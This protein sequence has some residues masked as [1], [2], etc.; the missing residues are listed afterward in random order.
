MLR[1]LTRSKVCSTLV[2]LFLGGVNSNAL[3]GSAMNPASTPPDAAQAASARRALDLLA[4]MTVEEKVGQLSQFFYIDASPTM[5]RRVETA[6]AGG[7]AGAVLFVSDPVKI[8]RLQKMAVEQ[9]RLK[10]PL[11]VGYDVIHGWNTILPVPIALAASWDPSVAEKAQAVAAAEASAA[12][13][14]WTFAPMIDV[15]LDPRWGRRVEGL[16]EDP[17]LGSAMTA[18]Q[19][20]GFQGPRLG[21]PAR[22]MAGPKHFAG[23]GAGMGGRDYDEAEISDSQLWNAYF[24]PFKAA[25]D[26]GAGNIMSAYMALN[27]VP[28]TGNHWL[29]TDVLRQTWGFKGFVVSDADAVSSLTRH[30]LSASASEAATLALKAGVNMEMISPMGAPVMPNIA[31]AIS[32][33]TV[34]VAELD[35]AV[36]PILET[37][38]R[39]GLFEHPYVDEAKA[40]QVAHSAAHDEVA[41]MAAERSAVL[42][43]NEGGLLPLN[44]ASLKSLAVIGPLA[45][46]GKDTLGPWA[47]QAKGPGVSVLEGLKARL[48][49]GVTI[50]HVDGVHLPARVFPSP[51]AAMNPTPPQPPIDEDA[52]IANAVH[53]ARQADVTVLVLGEGQDMAGEAASRASL[54]LP[55]RQQELLDA[56]VATGKPVVVLLMSSRPLN[57]HDT[58]AAA[59]MDI[60]YPGSQGGAAVARLLLG[61]VSPAG[62]LPFSWIRSAAQAPMTYAQLI[63]HEPQGAFKR[64]WDG[65][66][67]PTY[68]FGYG[69]SYTSFDYSHL[70]IEGEHHAIGDTVHVS[71]DVTNTGQRQCDEVAQL[72]LHQRSGTSS[73]PVRELK[74][75]ERLS[76]R[77]GETRSVHFALRPEDLRYWSAATRDWVQD[78]TSFDIWA[79]GSSAASLAGS[80]TIDPAEPK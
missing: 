36:L 25:I 20:R 55:G 72:Y 22:I 44:P 70:R 39:L 46:A 57:L 12:G 63:S 27:G 65:S 26:A 73:R 18:A 23:Y 58:K 34:S 30:G 24:P 31:K 69:L 42:L 3:A 41:R 54:D 74:G 56:V 40:A 43:R 1:H 2:A 68:P 32:Q 35:K 80:F 53:A 77:P 60:W 49:R 38:L 14:N 48:P 66:S 10:I 8:N 59:I 6:I 67:A 19:V 51:F 47:F 37:K 52:G 5:A 16:G 4:R 13:I 75:F 15:S 28:A 62:R 76:L 78:A 61:E 21:S 71:V 50:E 45:D 29:L 64:Y 11:L 7:Q 9:S 17:Y 79:G 33:G